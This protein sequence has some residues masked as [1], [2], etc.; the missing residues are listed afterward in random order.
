MVGKT[1]AGRPFPSIE[2]NADRFSGIEVERSP[3]T[4]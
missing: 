4:P 2:K 1:L 3:F